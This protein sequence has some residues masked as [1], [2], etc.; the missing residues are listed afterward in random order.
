MVM[1]SKAHRRPM[2]RRFM[3]WLL[4]SPYSGLL[5][6]SVMLIT[7]RGRRTGTEYRLPVQYAEEGRAIRIFPSHHE[8]RRR[9][10]TWSGSHRSGFGFGARTLGVP[11]KPSR[12]ES[13]SVVEEGLAAYVRWFPAVRR[14]FGVMNRGGAIDGQRLREMANDIVMVRIMAVFRGAGTCGRWRRSRWPSR[15][16]GSCRWGRVGSRASPTGS[17]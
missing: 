6:G 17:G 11:R 2:M 1:A 4:L 15:W 3:T 9:G 16:P 10:A 13:P 8:R 7:L 12:G 14:R 5:D